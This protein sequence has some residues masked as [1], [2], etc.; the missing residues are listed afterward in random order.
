[1]LAAVLVVNKFTV[2]FCRNPRDGIVD[3]PVPSM[4]DTPDILL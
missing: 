3:A 1:L 4:P 2:S